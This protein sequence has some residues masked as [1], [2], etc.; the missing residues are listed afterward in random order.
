M[1]KNGPGFLQY[2]HNHICTEILYFF[3]HPALLVIIRPPL[4]NLTGGYTVLG[5]GEGE[6]SKRMRG[7]KFW[8]YDSGLICKRLGASS[9]RDFLLLSLAIPPS[10]PASQPRVVLSEVRVG[11][12]QCRQWKSPGGTRYTEFLPLYL[13][14]WN[15]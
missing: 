15:M 6:S 11:G 3:Y 10:S 13:T 5:H 7:W 4:Q 9:L 12:E 14:T 1:P 2:G 8:C